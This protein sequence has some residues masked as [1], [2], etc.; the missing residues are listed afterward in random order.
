MPGVVFYYDQDPL[1]KYFS[2]YTGGHHWNAPAAITDADKGGPN[3]FALTEDGILDALK[4]KAS[5]YA[6]TEGV[7]DGKNFYDLINAIA[8]GKNTE[9]TLYILKGIHT[10]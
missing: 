6:T 9:Y 7:Q 10:K 4:S 8:T 1:K 5:S 3:D 2:A